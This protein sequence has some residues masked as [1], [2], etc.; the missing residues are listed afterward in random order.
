MSSEASDKKIYRLVHATARKLAKESIDAAPDGY[1][2]KIEPPGRTLE[3]NAYQFPYLEGFAQQL[4]WPVN[5]TMTSLTALEYKDILTAAFEN[6]INPRLAAGFDGGVVMLGR[7]TS[8][9]GKRK[10]AEWMTFL[11]AAAALKGI[12]PVFKGGE[13]KWEDER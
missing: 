13:R 12:T 11:M 1:S 5:G 3:Q 10:F 8:Q 2:C 4:L 6:D 7:K 9:F